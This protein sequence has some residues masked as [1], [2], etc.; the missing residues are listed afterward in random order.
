MFFGWGGFFRPFFFFFRFFFVRTHTACC[1]Y[2]AALP[3]LPGTILLVIYYFQL[4]FNH[5]RYIPG[6][7]L[8][9]LPTMEHIALPVRRHPQHSF[10]VQRY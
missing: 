5:I 6:I 9:S 10:V 1:K 7:H 3:H 8:R 4:V 2:E